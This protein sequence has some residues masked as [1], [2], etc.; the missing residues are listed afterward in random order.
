[1]DVTQLR[2]PEAPWAEKEVRSLQKEMSHWIL[3]VRDRICA[4]LVAIEQESSNPLTREQ[5]EGH[6]IYKPWLRRTDSGKSGGGGVM[7]ILKNGKVFEKAGVN[8]SAVLGTF[9]PMFLHEV[10]GAKEN[11]GKFWAGGLSMVLHPRSPLVPAFHMNVR[12]LTTAHHWF[13]GVLRL[14]PSDPRSPRHQK[15]S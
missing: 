14:K 1:M 12:M 5:P 11:D 9:S 3:D 10:P 15:F 8:V 2:I 7:G 13:G 4:A 6:F